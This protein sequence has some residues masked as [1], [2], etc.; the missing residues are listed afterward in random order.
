VA[1]VTLAQHDFLWAPG[2]AKWRVQPLVLGQIRSV[3]IKLVDAAP[4]DI[5]EIGAMQG[6]RPSGNAVVDEQGLLLAGRVLASSGQPQPGVEITARMEDMTARTTATDA[7]GYYVFGHI[8]RGAIVAVTARTVAGVCAPWRGEMIE[9][10]QNEAEL[11]VD[12][13]NC[14]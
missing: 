10:R 13:A 9:L 14:N 3:E 7:N 2:Y 1:A 5:L 12:L 4:S 6:L 8:K 11:D